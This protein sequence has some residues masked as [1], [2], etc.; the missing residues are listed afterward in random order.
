MGM[1]RMSVQVTGANE[2]SQSQLH[3]ARQSQK[4][5]CK[6]K[7]RYI[8]HWEEYGMLPHGTDHATTLYAKPRFENATL[9]CLS[10]HPPWWCSVWVYW[11]FAVLMLHE[12]Y[13]VFFNLKVRGVWMCLDRKLDVS[14]E[15]DDN[16]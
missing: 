3:L 9:Y 14:H 12:L 13:I 11:I 15:L 5:R 1:L 10:G 6:G 4:E 2:R 7:A 16:E 8:K